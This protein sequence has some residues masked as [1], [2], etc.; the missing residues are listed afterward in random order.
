[1]YINTCI[2]L[3]H[4]HT[5]HTHSRQ[6]ASTPHRT[7]A[8][9]MNVFSLIY[10]NA[11]YESVFVVQKHFCNGKIRLN[12]ICHTIAYTK[13]GT[14]AHRVT[15]GIHYTS[16]LMQGTF[17]ASSM[18]FALLRLT[19]A[20]FGKAVKTPRLAWFVR[21]RNEMRTMLMLSRWRRAV[22]SMLQN[23]H[24]YNRID[25]VPLMYTQMLYITRWW[26][27]K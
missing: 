9:Y 15:F 20:V 25:F 5:P 3:T 13:C 22:V 1:M 7:E 23:E 12:A 14:G 19:Q 18:R 4:T 6:P 11:K 8:D 17:W 27:E 16:T 10:A 2:V 21:Q 26:S 24:P